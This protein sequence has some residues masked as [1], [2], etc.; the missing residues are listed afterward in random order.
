MNIHLTPE[1]EQLVRTKVRT[2]GYNSA[3]DVV[4]EALRLMAERDLRRE[5]IREKI[6]EGLAS[7]RLGKLADGEA[8]LDRLEAELGAPLDLDR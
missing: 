2:G 8:V 7:Q 5:G 6:A 3:T 4:R 1:L